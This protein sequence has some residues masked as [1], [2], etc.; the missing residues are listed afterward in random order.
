MDLEIEQL[1]EEPWEFAVGLREY[2]ENLGDYTVVVTE[3]EYARYGAGS[4]PKHL[5]EATF[6]F[7]LEREDPEMILERFRLSDVEKH[8]SDFAD[9]VHDYL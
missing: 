7:L 3:D 2:D 5:V 8:F 4:E 6:K 1:S 9:A